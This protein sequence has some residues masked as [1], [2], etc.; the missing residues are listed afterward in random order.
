MPRADVVVLFE[1]YNFRDD[2]DHP[3]LKCGDFK[4]LLD[5]AKGPADPTNAMDNRDRE[6]EP[7][8][9]PDAAEV[10]GSSSYV[11][12][13]V[14]PPGVPTIEERLAATERWI[15]LMQKRLD[16]LNICVR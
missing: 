16:I 7:T 15:N 1:R 14:V 12:F 5:L 2:H 13:T 10:S 8:I 9:K 6:V 3:L 4:C 11:P